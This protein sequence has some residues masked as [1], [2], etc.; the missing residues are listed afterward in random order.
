MTAGEF[1]VRHPELVTVETGEALKD[2]K[3]ENQQELRET[4]NLLGIPAHARLNPNQLRLL[5][6]QIRQAIRRLL[7]VK[8]RGIEP[9]RQVRINTGMQSFTGVVYSV[10]TVGYVRIKGVGGSFNPT[11]VTPE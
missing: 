9:G 5:L 6:E 3:L 7:E 2:R 4:A 10:T 1:L 8:D 11:V